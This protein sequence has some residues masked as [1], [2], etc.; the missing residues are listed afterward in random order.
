MDVD[1]T[2]RLSCPKDYPTIATIYNESIQ[3]G[4]ITF[5][6]VQFTTDHIERWVMGMTPREGLWV[7]EGNR[8]ILG[9]GIL[10]RYSDRPAYH[11]TVESSIYLSHRHR[12][13]GYGARLQAELLTLAQ[14][15]DYHH[16]VAK[17]V[18]CNQ[19]SIEFHQRFGYEIVGIQKEVGFSRGKWYDIAILQCI[20][21]TQI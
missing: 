3:K 15:L 14:A 20:L 16:V 21:P 17:I 8:Q 1:T 7:I 9:W 18:A 4:G 10:K 13:Q 2:I 5:D 11:R 6:E 12:G 19:T